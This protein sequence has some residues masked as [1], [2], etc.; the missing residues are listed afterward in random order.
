[1]PTGIA[2]ERD[3]AVAEVVHVLRR[4]HR[5]RLAA[6]L[7]VLE[8]VLEELL[9]RVELAL[10]ELEVAEE[11][12]RAGGELVEPELPAL[13]QRALRVEQ[14]PAVLLAHFVRVRAGMR[15]EHAVVARRVAQDDLLQAREVEVLAVHF[16]ERRR[17]VAGEEILELAVLPGT[18][19]GEPVFVEG[20]GALV[21][22]A[23]DRVFRG[24][25]QKLQVLAAIAHV[26]RH[27]GL[28]SGF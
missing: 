2:I 6:A 14:G 16:E 12:V 20:Q 17:P 13:L 22:S 27:V 15:G 9:G 10:V 26:Y 19:E 21:V 24:L 23:P 25:A 7:E 11:V 4:E 18:R 8:R 1:M 5:V 28:T 3:V